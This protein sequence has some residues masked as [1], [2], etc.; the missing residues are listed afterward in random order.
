MRV[1]RWRDEREFKGED[2]YVCT[3]YTPEKQ[4]YGVD[5]TDTNERY[6]PTE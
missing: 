6:L 2:V 5:S 4:V 1:S 3:L